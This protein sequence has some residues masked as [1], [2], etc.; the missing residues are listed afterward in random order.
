MAYSCKWRYGIGLTQLV[1]KQQQ[2][3]SADAP[4]H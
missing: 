4:I 1:A 2:I 3:A